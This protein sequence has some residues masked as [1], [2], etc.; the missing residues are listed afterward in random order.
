MPFTTI[1]EVTIETFEARLSNLE[2]LKT[3]TELLVLCEGQ[4]DCYFYSAISDA[5]RS[6][7]LSLPKAIFLDSGGKYA[8]PD[9]I[10]QHRRQGVDVR[11][12][13]DFDVLR[14]E[15]PLHNVVEAL[16]GD[17][18]QV[19]P[20]WQKIRHGV[21]TQHQEGSAIKSKGQ[22]TEEF[23]LGHGKTRQH[24]KA[25]RTND[26]PW[27][28]AKRWGRRAVPERLQDAY[29]LLNA[30]LAEIGLFLVE[31]GELEGF[32]RGIGHHGA[33]WAGKVLKR[34]DAASAPELE[35]ARAFVRRV[36][37]TNPG[38]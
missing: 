23:S 26:L 24:I 13:V 29:D 22:E 12:I 31:V 10:R 16:G 2:P 17:W 18:T 5:L 33:R 15:S 14:T 21:Q 3:K 20:M 6:T 30:S 1:P 25:V 19:Q 9:L 37:D 38:E 8:L 34:Y 36:L 4:A 27:I 35:E 32:V 28:Q 7:D 11:V